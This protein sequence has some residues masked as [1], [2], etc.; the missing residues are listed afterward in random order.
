MPLTR[1]LG[2]RLSV[3]LMSGTSLDGIDA[4]LVAEWSWHS[5]YFLPE[6]V[7]GN[8]IQSFGVLDSYGCTHDYST[9]IFT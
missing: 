3:G 6:D 5:L 8:S 7:N 9:R 4:A 2:S 1:K